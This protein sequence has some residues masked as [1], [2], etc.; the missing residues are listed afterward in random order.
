[1]KK[2]ILILVTAVAW[3]CNTDEDTSDNGSS[4]PPKT[5]ACDTTTQCDPDC[6]HCDP[7]CTAN[8]VYPLSL[9]HI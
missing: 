4:P 5:C 9:I 6:A 1:M 2:L 3:A 8:G 7:D